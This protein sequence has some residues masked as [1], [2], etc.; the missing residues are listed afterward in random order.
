VHPVKAVGGNELS[1]GRDSG[2]VPIN[3]VLDRTG[4]PT[5]GKIWEL[6]VDIDA[7]YHQISLALLL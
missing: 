3:V 6:P 5:G 4:S 2:V 7:A 1:F